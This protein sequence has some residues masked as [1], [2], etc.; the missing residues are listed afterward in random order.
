MKE[1]S[2]LE[3]KMLGKDLGWKK[4]KKGGG[5]LEREER[6]KRERRAGREEGRE[7]SQDTEAV[8]MAMT[9]KEN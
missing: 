6:R 9:S 1:V 3:I 2:I 4:A 8:A 5:Q 7:A